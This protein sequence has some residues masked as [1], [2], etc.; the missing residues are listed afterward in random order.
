MMESDTHTPGHEV[1]ETPVVLFVEEKV[2]NSATERLLIV[3]VVDDFQHGLSVAR[4]WSKNQNMHFILN[5][6]CV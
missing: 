5:S 6:Q 3:F 4:P 2:T 1:G